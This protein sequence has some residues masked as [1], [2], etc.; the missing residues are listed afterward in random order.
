MKRIL[1]AAAFLG[2]LALSAS[3]QETTERQVLP[4]NVK[5]VRYELTVTPDAAAMTL[6]GDVRIEI[7]V[8][9]PTRTVTLNS[10]ELEFD[11]AEIDGTRATVSFDTTAQ[12]AT[13][14]VPRD[15]GVGRH[16]LA[17]AYRGK[18]YRQAQGLF[19]VD[20]DAAGGQ[21]RVLATQFEAADA[22]RFV[23]SFDEPSLKAVFD[24]TVI[25]PENRMV[26]SNMPEASSEAAGPGLKRVRFATSPKMSSYL[27]FLAVGDFERITTTVDGV[28]IGVVAKR[29]DAEH[30]RFALESAAQLLHYY[31]DY[32]GTPYPLPKLDMIAVP[33]GGGFAA[34]ENW[35]AILY[36]EEYL[37]LDPEHS[38]ESDRQTIYTDVAHEM[39]HQWFGDLVTMA[40]W[41]DLW[42]N[43]GFASWMERKATEHFHPDWNTWMQGQGRLQQA[44]DLDA[45]ATTHPVVQEIFT[46]DQA[47][48]AFDRITY[49]KGRAVIRMLE[50]HV[51][52]DPFR[53]GVRAYMREHAYA[54]ARTT[55][56]WAAIETASGQHIRQIANDFLLQPGIPLVTPEPGV[57]THNARTIT[58]RQSRFSLGEAQAAQRWHIPVAAALVNGAGAGGSIT[59]DNGVASFPLTGCGPFIVNPG[60]TSYQRTLYPR[61]SFDELSR[62]FARVPAPDQLTMLYDSVAFGLSGSAPYSDFFALAGRTPRN[63]DPLIWELIGEQVTVNDYRYSGLPSQAAYRAYAR[64]LLRPVLARIGW[65]KRSGEADNV[66]LLREQ[67]VSTLSSI[68][69]P[70][71]LAEARRRF[72]AD[73][74]PAPIRQ[75]VLFA[76]GRGADATTFDALL[77][78]AR[79]STDTIEKTTYYRALAHAT[80]PALAARALA[81]A[82]DED[83]NAALGTDIIDDVA[84]AH[85]RVA[86]DFA[87]AHPDELSA[88][89]DPLSR[90][91][92]LPRLTRF[93]VDP[94]LLADLRTHIDTQVPADLRRGQETAYGRFA[95][96]LRLRTERLPELDTWLATR[97]R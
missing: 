23:P 15:L 47:N 91:G 72:L 16:T 67:L 14:T 40:W 48:D 62:N 90:V 76:V 5:P 39:A 75:E 22:R 28:E 7:D 30:G 89:L 35:G 42:L 17:I 36:F 24:L 11:S 50:V 2:A 95:E 19:A 70:T 85:S 61:Q 81:I 32:F 33:G 84:Y 83:V 26:I 79:A 68:E 3:A 88:R 80:D 82:F 94:T 74:I 46:V 57:C 43:E 20:Y 12:T 25:V 73:D 97:S 41:D 8:T 93:S 64:N 87:V 59:D 53:D 55:D 1:I 63:A 37:L 44:M 10:L 71:V 52:E 18:I 96:R 45:R 92:Y 56:L 38:S 49:E 4:D 27:L 60:Q 31:N 69:D 21:E 86:W 9:A 58:L 13:L 34:M 54:N 66:S 6:A 77:S 65:E 29:G 51:G 78:R